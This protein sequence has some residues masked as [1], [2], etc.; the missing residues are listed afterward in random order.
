MSLAFDTF[1]VGTL[2][3]VAAGAVGALTI[4]HGWGWVLSTYRAYVARAKTKA[5]S[6]YAEV[7]SQ[8]EAATKEITGRVT[9]L[10]AAVD[11]IKQKTGA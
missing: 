5:D 4:E 8:V 6:V 9:A 3:G 1:S 11:A 7:T 10:E 2:A